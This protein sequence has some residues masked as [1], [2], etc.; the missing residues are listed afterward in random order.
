MKKRKL[1]RTG[2]DVGVIGHGL[3][4]M[5]GWT[6]S[7]DAQSFAAMQSAL[8]GGCNFFDSAF[9]Y[10]MGKSDGLLGK[11]IKTNPRKTIVAASKVPPKNW[12]W[13][14]PWG[15]AFEEAFPLHHVLS[16][17]TKTRDLVG[18]PLDLLQLHVWEDDWVRDHGDD[19]GRIA[20]KVKA[21]GI[22]RHFGI[23]LN[24]WEPGNGIEAI[25]TGHIDSVQVIYN[26]F[27]QAPEDELFP[28]C[29]KHNIG[30]IA[31][32]PLD[33]GSLGGAMTRETR[34][35][36]DDWRARYFNPENLAATLD[37]VDAL[38]KI[39]PHGMTLPE[40][41]MRFAAQHEAVSTVIVGMRK[42]DHVRMNLAAG[43]G[44]RLGDD[45]MQELRGH[46]WNRKPAPWSD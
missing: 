9:A 6:G 14:P 26:I 10:G 38:K 40:M 36:K 3:W 35:P 46:R 45:L 2:I 22:T 19:L 8:D 32:V 42:P 11:F 27:D 24:R 20:E 12:K 28:A 5:G 1:G 13:P 4:G 37:R 25:E 16:F 30:V 41:A 23:S 18:R 21:E 33:E 31:R 29:L 43:D 7:D 15:C 34:F 39:V 17:G 44:K